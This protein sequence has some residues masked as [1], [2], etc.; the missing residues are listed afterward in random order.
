MEFFN[1]YFKGYLK[2]IASTKHGGSVYN[3]INAFGNY[4]DLKQELESDKSIKNDTLREL[5][6][7]KG[8]VEFYYSPDINQQ[9]VKSV[10]EQLYHET[11][12][13]EH[14]KIA[15]NALQNF[16]QLQTG[17]DAP[18]FMANDLKG[19]PFQLNS[20]KGQYI[21]LNF[22]STQ[23]EISLKEM[24]K[25]IDLKNNFNGKITFVSVCLDDSVKH[26]L[27]HLKN[28]PK[29]NWIILHQAKNSTAKQAYSITSLSGFFFINKQLQLSQSPA[30]AP[31]EGIEYKFNAL[32]KTRKKNTMPGIR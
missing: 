13:S 26:F 7:L 16:Y 19:M 4:K 24:Q 17:A 3:S 28:N 27:A 20:L 8:L 6:T 30:L 22:F 23:S 1:T 14:Q 32:F 21:Y 5:L 29:Q 31:S 9:Q 15:L 2:G 18:N 25:I 12:I 11:K 10:L